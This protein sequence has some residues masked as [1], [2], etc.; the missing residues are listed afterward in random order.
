M[1]DS[2]ALRVLYNPDGVDF[3]QKI[4]LDMGNG[5]SIDASAN[6]FFQKPRLQTRQTRLLQLRGVSACTRSCKK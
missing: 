4:T 1:P 3:A 6:H 2:L 5:T